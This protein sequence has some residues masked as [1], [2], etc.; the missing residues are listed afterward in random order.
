[1]EM[2]DDSVNCYSGDLRMHIVSRDTT[3]ELDDKEQK[4]GNRNY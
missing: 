4:R 1:M 2:N 3:R